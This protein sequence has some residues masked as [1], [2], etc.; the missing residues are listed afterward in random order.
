MW[1]ALNCNRCCELL[2]IDTQLFRWDVC[3]PVV[4]VNVFVMF[5]FSDFFCIFFESV[6]GNWVKICAFYIGTI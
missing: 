6:I 2:R 1:I 5:V 4:F 3:L